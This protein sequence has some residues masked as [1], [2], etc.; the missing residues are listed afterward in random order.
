MPN[1][2]DLKFDDIAVGYEASFEV[3]IT[4][5]LVSR[6]ADI[7]GDTN[8]LHMD[9]TYA[10]QSEF[11]GRVVHGMLG[12]SFFSRLVGMHLPGKYA[13]YLSQ[14]VLFRQPMRIGMKL[15]VKGTV[16]QKIAG[17]RTIKIKTEIFDVSS[18]VCFTDGEALVK[19]LS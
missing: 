7:S 12:A 6:F 8:P 3:E 5:D 11:H 18:G 14:Q 9:E 2:N 17:V 1:C 16:I 4:D 13:L 19:L 10:N 15:Q